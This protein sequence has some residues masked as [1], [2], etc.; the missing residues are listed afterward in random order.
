MKQK[1]SKKRSA[2]D[3]VEEEEDLG[4]V[5]T[6]LSGTKSPGS[7]SS[8]KTPKTPKSKIKKKSG[9][10][11]QLMSKFE[12]VTSETLFSPKKDSKSNIEVEKQLKT[13]VSSILTPQNLAKNDRVALIDRV[14]KA[15]SKMTLV[16]PK[17][18]ILTPRVSDISSITLRDSKALEKPFSK[19][20][21]EFFDAVFDLSVRRN[22]RPVWKNV[23]T[24]KKTVQNIDTGA[25]TTINLDLLTDFNDLKLKTVK[26][27][28]QK[29]WQ[30]PNAD[31]L[32]ED[33]KSLL[34]TRSV[35]AKLL[36]KSI[37]KDLLDELM[38][39]VLAELATDG[40]VLWLYLVKTIFPS[41]N[42]LKK[43]IKK[44]LGRIS[45][46]DCNDCYTTYLRKLTQALKWIKNHDDIESQ[47]IKN[48]LQTMKNHP[49]AAICRYFNDQQ[50]KR[51][52]YL[53][54]V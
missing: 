40:T 33:G 48:F 4:S 3:L 11:K 31:S 42:V 43:Q 29:L 52:N 35:L 21:E 44:S 1:S 10:F 2:G 23:L 19:E 28:A 15:A 45:L 22:M 53:K 5:E 34:Y 54:P 50:V 38:T 9:Q 39:V 37:E 24:F 20:P 49:I 12:P 13:S 18:P 27:E 46:E 7:T 8:S 14:T 26:S 51:S 47:I 17:S 32:A 6:S 30:N 16:T 41:S 25:K 36:T